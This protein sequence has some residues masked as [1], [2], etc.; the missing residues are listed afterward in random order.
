MGTIQSNFFQRTTRYI[1]DNNGRVICQSGWKEAANPD[2]LQPCSEPICNHNGVGCV[3]GECRS[4]DYCACEVGWEGVSCDICIPL[5]GCENGNCTDTALECNCFEGWSGAYC[6]IR[7]IKNYKSCGMY[8]LRFLNSSW[9]SDFR[10]CQWK[11][12]QSKWLHVSSRFY[13]FFFMKMKLFFSWNHSCFDGW[14]GEKCDQCLKLPGCV[15]GQCGSH[16]NTCECNP[17]WEG[18][19]CDEPVCE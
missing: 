14:E 5:P 7:K 1:C 3:N 13:L 18:H 15:N 10:M 19:L 8:L 11:M 17:G 16:P 2:P 12:S 9:L 4:P 6:E